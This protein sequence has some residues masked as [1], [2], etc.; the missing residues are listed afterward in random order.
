MRGEGSAVFVD[1]LLGTLI[2]VAALPS[3]PP[4]HHHRR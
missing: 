4:R 3:P 1:I 2:A